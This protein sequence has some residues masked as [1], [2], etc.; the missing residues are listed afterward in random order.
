MKRNAFLFLILFFWLI[1]PGFFHS[2]SAQETPSVSETSSSLKKEEEVKSSDPFSNQTSTPFNVNPDNFKSMR[3][4][5]SG[6]VLTIPGYEIKGEEVLLP[7]ENWS[8][9]RILTNF[10]TKVSFDSQSSI[11][12]LTRDE[13]K[14]MRM[15]IDH[16]AAEILGEMKEIPIPPRLID[17]KPYISPSSFCKFI[18]AFYKLDEKNNLYYL[19]PWVLDVFLETT[20]R[21][22]VLLVAKG[23]GRLQYKV[24]K[25]KEPTRFV[26]D[27]HNA[28]LDG[29]QRETA[30][31]TLGAI[32]FSQNEL[33][34]ENGNIVR[35]VIPESEDIEIV[36]DKPRSLEFVEANLRPR[37]VAAPVQDFAVQSIREL[38]V[39]ETAN[40]VTVEVNTTGPVQLEWNRLMNPDNRFFIDIPSMVYPEKKKDFDMK[41]DFVK[42]IRAAQFQPQPNPIVR[43]VLELENPQKVTIDTDSKNHNQVK[44]HI[45]KTVIDPEKTA[46][47]GYVVTHYPTGGLVICLDPG[48]GGSDPGAVNRAVGLQEKNLTLD[49]SNRLKTLLIKEGWTVVMTRTTDRDVSYAGSRDYEELGA[50]TRIANDLKADIFVS[51]H[52]NASTNTKANG[53]ATFWYKWQDKDLAE[54]IQSGLAFATN[55]RNIGIRRERFFLLRASQMPAALVEICFIS[56]PEDAKMLAQPEFRQKAAV[57]IMNGLRAYAQ[58]KQLKKK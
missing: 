16:N 30:H 37:Q 40:R 3:F 45:D 51:I 25:L 53:V 23:T 32:R 34:G 58:K 27:V 52:I 5:S 39:T 4:T 48:H 33:M 41:V 46:R 38:K 24:L 12:T 22:K 17:G 55:R 56:N 18:W 50:R 6:V 2:I 26:I 31:P 15:K 29:R 36:M 10:N 35:I 1:S 49:I 20:A 28:V 42:R 13:T 7:V 14:I 54:M 9:Q 19:D 47:K 57:G 11:I 21:G 8:L 44:I 43:M